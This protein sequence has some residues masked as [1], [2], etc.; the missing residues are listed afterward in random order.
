M[1]YLR[2]DNGHFIQSFLRLSYTRITYKTCVTLQSTN[3]R[4]CLTGTSVQQYRIMRFSI[5]SRNVKKV[6]APARKNNDRK[7]LINI[8]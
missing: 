7:P 1:N 8:L 2:D 3:N 6:F 4:L 5:R